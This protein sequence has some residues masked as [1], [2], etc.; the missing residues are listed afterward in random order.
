M[1]DTTNALRALADRVLGLTVV[2]DVCG[3]ERNAIAAELRALATRQAQGGGGEVV[4]CDCK[5]PVPRFGKFNEPCPG[6]A[7]SVIE[8]QG[9]G[10]D[11]P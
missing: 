2:G 6:C 1:T 10:E 4:C 8:T 5:R 7:A 9:G 3:T 11:A